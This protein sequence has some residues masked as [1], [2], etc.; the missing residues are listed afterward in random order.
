MK[1][2][3]NFVHRQICPTI[4]TVEEA[5]NR[6]KKLLI[7]DV[8]NPKYVTNIIPRSQR[9]NESILLKDIPK[10][11]AVLVTC[12]SGERSF[13]V[14][15]QLIQRGYC[16]VYVLKGGVIAWRRAGYMTQLIKLPA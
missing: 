8:Q 6:Q 10:T 2:Q 16:D 12:L 9:L 4:L 13:K 11:Q 7:V 1:T 14:A 15:Q 5:M 3:T